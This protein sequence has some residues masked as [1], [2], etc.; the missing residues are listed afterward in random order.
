MLLMTMITVVELAV[1]VMMTCKDDEDDDDYGIFQ[2]Y[3]K[4][5][6]LQMI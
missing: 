4:H 3:V 6:I 5:V 1:V 2:P